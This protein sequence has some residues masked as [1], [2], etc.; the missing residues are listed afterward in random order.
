MPLQAPLP[1]KYL[2]SVP[3]LVPKFQRLLKLLLLPQVHLLLPLLLLQVYHVLITSKS[4]QLQASS[5]LLPIYSRNYTDN[6]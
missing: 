6:S 2:L 3:L 1:L 4:L 5:E